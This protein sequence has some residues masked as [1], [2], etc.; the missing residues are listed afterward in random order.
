MFPTL[1]VAD[2]EHAL[3]NVSQS[4]EQLAN[5][6]NH[7]IS[8][9]EVEYKAMSKIVL[10]THLAVVNSLLASK[11]GI[12]VLINESCCALIELSI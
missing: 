11:R 7:S 1:G 6:N 9:L 3:I 5:T 12:C 10:Q 2:L 8:N 4:T